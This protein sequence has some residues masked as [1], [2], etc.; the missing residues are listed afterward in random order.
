MPGQVRLQHGQQR[1]CQRHS[2]MQHRSRSHS[3]TVTLAA[4][5]VAALAVLAVPA[6]TQTDINNSFS[7]YNFVPAVGPAPACRLNVRCQH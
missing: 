1:P 6:A 5:A 2:R 3:V 4:V 7:D